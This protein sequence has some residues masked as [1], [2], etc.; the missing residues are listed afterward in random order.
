MTEAPDRHIPVMA[1][2]VLALLGAAPGALLVDLTVGGGGHADAFLRATAPTGTVI[3]C[4]RDEQALAVA[5]ARLAEYGDRVRLSHGDSV[6][7][8][9]RLHAEGVRADAVLIDLGL[10]SM[11]LD[12]AE[13]GF[14]LREDGPLDMRMDTSTGTTAAEFLHKSAEDVIARALAEGGDEPAAARIARAIVERRAQRPFHTTGDLRTLVEAVLGRRYGRVHPAT[15]TFQGV[16]MAVNRELELLEQALPMAMDLL[17]ADGRLAVI[18]FHSGED[19]IVKRVFAEA[20]TGGYELVTRK[21]CVPER[22]EA[23]RNRRSR[24]ARLRVLRRR[25]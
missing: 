4:D 21:P 14:S 15:R 25:S 2:E 8:L 3:G 18:S 19:R 9:A 10:S 16:R 1:G 17:R 13:R 20:A 7:C 24:S 11:Q 6:S 23:A 22:A 5:H 12:D